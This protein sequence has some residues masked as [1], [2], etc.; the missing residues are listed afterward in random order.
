VVVAGGVWS[1]EE[2]RERPGCTRELGW[3]RSGLRWASAAKCRG[4]E[5]VNE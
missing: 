1:K 2:E 3:P 4:S 5:R